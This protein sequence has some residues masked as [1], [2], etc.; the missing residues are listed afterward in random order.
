MTASMTSIFAIG[1]AIQWSLRFNAAKQIFLTQTITS[2][3]NWNVADSVRAR[4][5]FSYIHSDEVDDVVT[6]PEAEAENY[7]K[8]YAELSVNFGLP[9]K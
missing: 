8:V 1:T 6:D 5:G 9:L 2:D 3:L 4:A 7:I